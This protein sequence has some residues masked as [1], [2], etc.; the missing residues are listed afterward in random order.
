MGWGL[1]P[2]PFSGVF[3]TE[4]EKAKKRYEKKAAKQQEEKVVPIRKPPK[5]MVIVT[6]VDGG[7]RHEYAFLTPQLSGT[8]ISSQ[9]NYGAYKDALGTFIH[10]EFG[11]WQLVPIP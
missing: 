2:P 1:R 7:I 4:F 9:R 5:D 8:R 11:Q 6:I 3:M 10:K